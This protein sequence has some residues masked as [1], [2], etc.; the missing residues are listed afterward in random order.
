MF[1]IHLDLPELG[2]ISHRIRQV[3]FLI[4]FKLPVKTQH[5]DPHVKRDREG[6]RTSH[7]Y[8]VGRAGFSILAIHKAGTPREPRIPPF[9]QC[10]YHKAN[11]FYFYFYFLHLDLIVPIVELYACLSSF[12]S[13]CAC[14][15]N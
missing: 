11:I 2:S 10:V 13:Q 5:N 3:K 9:S 12:F 6:E 8:S 1:K 15:S 4:F 14:V 7:P